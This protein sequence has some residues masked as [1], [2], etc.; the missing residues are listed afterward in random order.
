MLARGSPGVFDLIVA[1]VSGMAAAYASGRPNLVSALPGV[2]IAA[3]LVPPIAT[4]GL[5]LA[6]GQ[7]QLAAGALLLFL[8]NIVAIVLGAACSLWAV[9]IRGTHEHG[10]LSSWAQRALIA[11]LL[12]ALGLAAY[13]WGINI[14]P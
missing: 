7:W 1:F 12:I 8:T 14:A 11:L 10:F 4:A 3:A 13:E 5:G 2:A 6:A 9:G